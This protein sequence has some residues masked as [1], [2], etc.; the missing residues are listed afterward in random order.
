M[1][2]QILN[3]KLLSHL[4]FLIMTV[5]ASES[6]PFVNE[7]HVIHPYAIRKFECWISDSHPNVASVFVKHS[8]NNSNEFSDEVVGEPSGV[9]ASYSFE[10]ET[11]QEGYGYEVIGETAEN[12]FILH[13]L[14]ITSVRSIFHSLIA[15]QMDE[16]EVNRYGKNTLE[17]RFTLRGYQSLGDRFLGR[18][19]IER[20]LI[21]VNGTSNKDIEQNFTWQPVQGVHRSEHHQG[22]HLSDR[23]SRHLDK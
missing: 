20:S 17:K 21:K 22:F 9:L 5:H 3:M 15:L 12:L 7:K 8:L 19:T 14:N 2:K 16:I 18:V 10:N 1:I 13:T 6:N 23:R 11:R 4:L